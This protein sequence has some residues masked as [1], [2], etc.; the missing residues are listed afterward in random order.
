MAACLVHQ[1]LA[2][3]ACPG[4]SSRNHRSSSSPREKPE[5]REGEKRERDR[6]RKA[7]HLATEAEEG[8]EE[9]EDED[10]ECDWTL[11]SPCAW[12]PSRQVRYV[13]LGSCVGIGTLCLAAPLAPC[14]AQRALG[15]ASRC[16]SGRT[17][18]NG[19]ITWAAGGTSPGKLMKRATAHLRGGEDGDGAAFSS[20][21]L[22]V[23]LTQAYTPTASHLPDDEPEGFEI[24]HDKALPEY[25][26]RDKHSYSPAQAFER[27]LELEDRCSGVTCEM[28][29]LKRPLTMK[30]TPPPRASRNELAKLLV[31]N[32]R[33]YNRSSGKVERFDPFGGGEKPRFRNG[34]IVGGLLTGLYLCTVRASWFHM[35]A[36]VNT[37][38]YR[39]RRDGI[40]RHPTRVAE[41]GGDPGL[42]SVDN[43]TSPPPPAV[44]ADNAPAAD[45]LA[46]L[47][48]SPGR[49]NARKPRRSLQD[50]SVL[51]PAMGFDR[52]Q[53]CWIARGKCESSAK[54]HELHPEGLAS[55]TRPSLILDIENFVL[56]DEITLWG[57][58][59][60]ADARL[61]RVASELSPYTIWMPSERDEKKQQ[62]KFRLRFRHNAE[63]GELLDLSL[64]CDS[65]T[66]ATV[67]LLPPH[68]V[69]NAHHLHKDL[70]MKVAFLLKHF[71]L[72]AKDTQLYL[73]NGDSK[74]W[75]RHIVMMHMLDAVFQ[76]VVYPFEMLTTAG[77]NRCHR[78]MLYTPAFSWPTPDWAG[79]EATYGR[80]GQQNWRGVAAHWVSLVAQSLNLTHYYTA[81]NAAKRCEMLLESAVPKL[82]WLA[83]GKGAH[84]RRILNLGTVLEEM[85]KSFLVTTLG[86]KAS[87]FEDKHWPLAKQTLTALLRQLAD[88]DILAGYFGAGIANMLYLRPGALAV[89]IQ[90]PGYWFSQRIFLNLAAHR[91][92]SFYIADVT[93]HHHERDGINNVELPIDFIEG[94]REDMLERLKSE[95]A[96]KLPVSA[97]VLE[98]PEEAAAALLEPVFES[99]WDSEDGRCQPGDSLQWDRGALGSAR[100]S[101][102]RL[103]RCYLVRTSDGVWGTSDFHTWDSGLGK[104]AA[105]LQQA[106]AALPRASL[107]GTPEAICQWTRQRSWKTFSTSLYPVLPQRFP[108][109]DISAVVAFA[110]PNSTSAWSAFVEAFS[111]WYFARSLAMEQRLAHHLVWEPGSERFLSEDSPLELI[112][113]LPSFYAIGAEDDGTSLLRV[114]QRQSVLCD[115]HFAHSPLECKGLASA[116]EA[117]A[118]AFFNFADGSLK[119]CGEGCPAWEARLRPV[120]RAALERAL[121]L[122]GP[123]FNSAAAG[124]PPPGLTTL[125]VCPYGSDEDVDILPASAYRRAG[126]GLQLEDLVIVVAPLPIDSEAE[127]RCRALL[128]GLP[129]SLQAAANAWLRDA[130]MERRLPEPQLRKGL[131]ATMAFAS[132]VL[133][134]SLLCPPESARKAMCFWAALGGGASILTSGRRLFEGHRPA[135]PPQAAWIDDVRPVR[136]SHTQLNSPL[137]ADQAA[138][139]SPQELLQWIRMS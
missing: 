96:V 136:K 117:F 84:N 65:R 91:G 4:K 46:M 115:C 25:A 58:K 139:M 118:A 20:G 131:S 92:L 51:A 73:F 1:Q 74:L 8:L 98:Q 53:D 42:A 125:F 52:R 71:R 113:S 57:L 129:S 110:E 124:P 77:T 116:D 17:S 27:C 97:L 18:W 24:L 67:L 88:A 43:D 134:R 114:R 126:L 103:S 100:L 101:R 49:L 54:W 12:C 78:R 38:S 93:R 21:P 94:L 119:S 105:Q 99:G 34:Q 56:T 16:D 62:E 102:F 112:G 86:K 121:Q 23:Q 50:P 14:E 19:D 133:G 108:D 13:C 36:P 68:H 83:R 61:Q 106:T 128:R 130:G 127:E 7:R 104:K 82:V 39:K 60:A 55:I 137:P 85:Q 35:S 40:A 70:I 5:R 32:G 66:A 90:G 87:D 26:A 44:H 95:C 80:W 9:E 135:L 122:Q 41:N 109:R 37:I 123:V 89:V 2:A 45:V 138:R 79:Y 63:A 22:A 111:V 15:L 69:D 33:I 29:K 76:K 10:E 31:Q 11:L 107:P 48:P 6:R 120:L 30:T 3:A 132:L 75:K 59:S 28:E 72:K 64:G 81:A 47:S